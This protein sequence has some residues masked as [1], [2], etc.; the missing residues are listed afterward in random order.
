MTDDPEF[1][2]LFAEAQEVEDAILTIVD[3][4]DPDLT[5]FV[6]HNT[7]MSMLMRVH[8]MGWGEE[9]IITHLREMLKIAREA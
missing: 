6:C 5:G 1:D 2:A 8:L 9:E 4:L 7:A 3:R